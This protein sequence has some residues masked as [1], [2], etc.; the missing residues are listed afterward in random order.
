M[1][2]IQ[3]SCIRLIF[4]LEDRESVTTRLHSLKWINL[5]QYQIGQCICLNIIKRQLPVY[6]AERLVFRNG[7]H[8]MQ[9]R[10]RYFLLGTFKEV[11]YITA[12]VI[13]QYTSTYKINSFKKIINIC[14][15]KTYWQSQPWKFS[16]YMFVCSLDCDLAV[17]NKIE[18]I[19]RERK[20][21]QEP[22]CGWS[23]DYTPFS[24]HQFYL[25]CI[26]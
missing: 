24:T 23:V 26:I 18:H 20:E 1:Q 13:C 16:C 22:N 25:I 11:F 21:D 12:K 14:L 4:R 17:I 10:C 8:S 2:I 3:N 7:I 6:L 19:C 15:L 5:K 9:V